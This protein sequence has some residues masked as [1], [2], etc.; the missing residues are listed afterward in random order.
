[1]KKKRLWKS[2]EI[3]GNALAFEAFPF[4]FQKILGRGDNLGLQ[5]INVRALPG[6]RH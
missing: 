1:M 4:E 6:R 3:M 5:I 2:L